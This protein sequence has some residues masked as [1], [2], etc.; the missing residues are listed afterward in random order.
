MRRSTCKNLLI[1]EPSV[2]QVRHDVFRKQA[3]ENA[4]IAALEIPT[5]DQGDNI[6]S[7]LCQ[8][9]L[10]ELL[11]M[12]WVWARCQDMPNKQVLYVIWLKGSRDVGESTHEC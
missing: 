6:P 1:K 5:S 10:G 9:L 12:G 11:E 7:I 3:L 4:S 8:L 2:L